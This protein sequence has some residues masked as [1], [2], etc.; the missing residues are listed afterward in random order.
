MT[1]RSELSLIKPRQGWFPANVHAFSTLR[2]GGV[3][4]APYHGRGAG[5]G[6]N[7]G[8]HVGDA[9]EMVA[10]NRLILDSHLP[11]RVTFLSQVHGIDVVDAAKLSQNQIADGSLT[12]KAGVVCAVL[13]ADC[14]PVLLSDQSGTVVAAVHAGWRGLASGILQV[15]VQKMRESGADDIL[16]WMGPAIGP[17]RF[18][19]GREVVD[20]FSTL[21][22]AVSD[23][24]ISS[25]NKDKY[26]ANIYSLARH[27]LAE[28]G[29]H[30]LDGGIH[31]TVTESDKFYSYRRDGKTGRMASVIWMD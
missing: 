24:F 22:A 31:C 16:A 17:S 3:S 12:D 5:A 8:D 4:H 18:E 19:V 29:V 27:A 6:L 26:L 25:K 14:L 7:L 13:T 9:A 21:G 10:Q 1:I 2:E 11:S 20:T 28:V 23:C 15:A 30:Q